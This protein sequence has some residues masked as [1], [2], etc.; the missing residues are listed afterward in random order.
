M[1]D[2][3]WMPEKVYAV[4]DV[5]LEPDSG[6]RF[7]VFCPEHPEQPPDGGFYCSWPAGLLP[8]SVIAGDPECPVGFR[9]LTP[10]RSAS[11]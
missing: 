6:R 3:V 5:I 1:T 7:E 10:A 11:H 4:G 8:P 2:L 9:E